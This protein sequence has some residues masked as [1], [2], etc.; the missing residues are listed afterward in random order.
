MNTDA[1]PVD[2]YTYP[3]KSL[4]EFFKTKT[5]PVFSTTTN[6]DITLFK[7]Y[8]DQHQLPFFISFSYLIHCICNK[9]EPFKLRII[10]DQLYRFDFLHNSFTIATDKQG[11]YSFGDV[12]YNLNF[13]SYSKQAA[14]CIKANQKNNYI[15]NNNINKQ[16]C[17]FITSIPW[18]SFT[19]F[20]HP[21]DPINGSIPIIT[22]GKYY[23]NN[24]QLVM[25]VAVQVHHALMDGYHVGEFYN[26]LQNALNNPENFMKG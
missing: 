18:F 8:I 9:L 2:L 12:A 19:S 24:L 15:P 3:R 17:V 11:A 23:Y 6:I 7:K 1:Q 25:P 5:Y 13:V 26:F 10:N 20:Q 22:L 21:F 16:Q 14:A 4:Y